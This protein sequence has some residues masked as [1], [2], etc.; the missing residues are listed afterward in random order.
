MKH[1]V[2]NDSERKQVEQLW[3]T[4]IDTFK[5]DEQLVDHD[6]LSV[7]DQMEDEGS[8]S[9]DEEVV[10]LLTRLLDNVEEFNDLR[11]KIIHLMEED[12]M[13]ETKL[14]NLF[15]ALI[16]SGLRSVRTGFARAKLK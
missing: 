2:R 9:L 6:P 11:K 7:L 14:V 3:P 4:S 8:S 5:D 15:L 12:D 13:T 10:A 1:L 16:Q